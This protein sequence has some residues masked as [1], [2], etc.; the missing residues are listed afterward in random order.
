M[1]TFL[2]QHAAS[3]IGVINGFDRLRF[4]GTWRRIS[5]VRG[6]G[7]FLC[8]MKVLLKDAGQ[9]MNARTEQVKKASLAVADS[10]GRPVEYVNDPSARKEDLARGS[11]NVTGSKRGWCAC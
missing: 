3:V 7:S 6:L 4:R 9:W 2:R 5:S 1:L 10:Q 8:Y 11:P